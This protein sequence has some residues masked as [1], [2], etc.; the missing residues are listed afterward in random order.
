MI[1]TEDY[2]YGKLGDLELKASV[3][4]S[5]KSDAVHTLLYFHGGGLIYGERND[6]P[7]PHLE[8]LLEGGH[9][10]IAFDY[11]LA[12]EAGLSE[13]VWA[14]KEAVKWFD[15]EWDKELGLASASFSLF[16]RSAGAY[17]CLLLA[18]DEELPKPKS[19]IDFYGY[20][21][22]DHKAFREPAPYY[23]NYPRMKEALIQ[24]MVKASPIAEGPKETRYAIYLYAR[25]TGKWLE[26]L[27]LSKEQAESAYRLTE[28]EI[29][30]LPPIFIAHSTKDPDVPFHI[31]E[32]IDAKAPVSEFF[33][34][35]GNEHD[36]DRHTDSKPAKDVYSRLLE[37]LSGE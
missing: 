1:K 15:R 28:K 33:K 13:I 34:V 3:Y 19:L 12:P 14:G 31:A 11:P 26:L 35:E 2:I 9:H 24:R 18:K 17:L 25:Q 20:A 30:D 5:N 29:E 27:H 22:L 4:R 23:L 21:S 37:W 32:R 16:G 10:V 7:E 6:L 8:R 36:F